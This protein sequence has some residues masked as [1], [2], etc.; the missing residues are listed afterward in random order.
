MTRN[1]MNEQYALW[2]TNN[3]ECENGRHT[4]KN[5]DRLTNS[6]TLN[7]LVVIIRNVVC[8]NHV[9]KLTKEERHNI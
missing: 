8:I 6:I 7:E 1:V 2:I 9:C 5:I 3:K 4:N